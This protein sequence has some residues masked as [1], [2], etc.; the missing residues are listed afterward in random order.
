MVPYALSASQGINPSMVATAI[1]TLIAGIGVFLI[2]CK[3]MS[4]NL[5]SLSSNKLKSLFAKTSKSKLIG[6][7][8]GTVATAAIQSSGATTVMVIGFVNAGIMSLMQAATI[9][10]GANIGT[11]ITGQI[12]ALGMFGANAIST[13]IVFSAFAGIGAFI[14][15]FAKKD[16]VQKVGGILAGFGML[17]VG[18]NMMSGSM[19]EFASL[20]S[21]KHFLASIS[22][23]VLLVLIGAILT[24]V[25]QSSSVMTSLAITM[26]FTGLITLDQGIYLTLGSNIGSCVVAIIAGI[27]SG[28]NAK[29]TALIHLIFNIAGVVVFMLVGLILREAS[30]G[31][32]TFGSL[33]AKMFPNA[34]NTQMAMFHTI[35]NVITVILILPLTN[36]LVKLV[37]KIIPEKKKKE[38]KDAP[39]LYYI[40]EHLLTTPPIAVQQTKNEIV[41]MAEIA[42]RNF[43][44][45]CDIVCSMD[46]KNI[47]KFRNNENQLNFLNKELVRF[48]IKLSKLEMSDKDR[49]YLSSALH[50]IT[51]LERVGDYA[52]NIVEYAEKMSSADEQFSD[53]AVEEIHEMQQLIDELYQKVMKAYVNGDMASL[54]E[55]NAIEE[56][57]DE[58]T[59]QMQDGHIRRMDKGICTSDIGAQY[60]SLASNAERVADHFINVAKTIKDYSVK[61]KRP[62]K[63]K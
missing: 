3:M 58:F 32:I 43:T 20:D 28:T 45:S 44:L 47:E 41:N 31:S 21:V 5:E 56:R 17:F 62:A 34:L 42:M 61:K 60:M 13:T 12:V 15:M 24:A 10:F 23:P 33:F 38:D 14:M 50:T 16:V 54:K 18:L 39:H 46:F 8:I 19:E 52:E 29:R 4:S 30:K 6:V 27:G 49:M 53:D 11:T 9:I 25:I 35:F 48:I 63:A 51:D 1:L 40:D 22:N 36:L 7:G 55:A 59:E 2:A 57:I 37:T 26:V